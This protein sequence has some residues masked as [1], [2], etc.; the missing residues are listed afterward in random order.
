ML[1]DKDKIIKGY[2]ATDDDMKCRGFQFELDVWYEHQGELSLCN[3]GFHFC[4]Y[5]SGPW[6]YYGNGRLFHVEAKEVLVSTGPGADLKHVARFIRL[7]SEIKIDGNRNTGNRNTG[8]WNT[9]DRN[10]GDWNT[11]NRNT[12]DRNTGNRNTG[13]RNTG[14]WNTGNGNTGD[15]NTGD[16]NTGDWNTGDWNTGDWNT[17]NGNTGDWNTGDWNTGNG[18]TGNGNT[19]DYHAGSLNI[20][21][22]PFLLFNKKADREKVDFYLVREL[23][24][25]L[26]G[27]DDI[28]PN[29]FL[30][31][32]NATASAIL[33]LHKAHIAARN[34]RKGNKA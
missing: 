12:G 31:L 19:G 26:M 28:N 15:W 16:R 3:S 24:Q 9:G 30:S 1:T 4:E 23:S 7:V 11:G 6:C 17:G 33:K 8:N 22:A 29:Q 27:D 34:Q 2:K 32:P 20:G 13:N 5:P 14:D 10:T 21:D 25:L 18:N